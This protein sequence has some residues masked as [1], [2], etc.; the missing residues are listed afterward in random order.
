[1]TSDPN[2]DS[3]D[4]L[5]MRT[6]A[7]V[8]LAGFTALT[9]VHG[10]EAAADVV[11]QFTRDARD[12]VAQR[13]ELVKTMGD[14]VMLVFPGPEEALAGVGDL[15]D[16]YHSAPDL[17]APRAGMHHGRAVHRG[18]DWIGASVNLAARVAAEA[19]SGQAL[20]TATIAAQATKLGLPVADLGLFQLRNVIE[21]VELFDIT[22]VSRTE[23]VSIDPVCRMQ[24]AHSGAF[25]V[26]RHAGADLRFCSAQCLRSFLENPARYL[27]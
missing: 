24:V 5:A 13:G 21:P 16:R 6:F 10:D 1:M 7:F 11:D 8:D 19:S 26:V 18:E 9:E 2:G 17:P 15:L 22:L 14:A 4:A 25:A 27:G 20:A 12:A 23:V 3:D